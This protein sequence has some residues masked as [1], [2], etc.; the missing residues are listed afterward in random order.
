MVPF[1][2]NRRFDLFLNTTCLDVV[3]EEIVCILVS[4]S[5]SNGNLIEQGELEGGRHHVLWEDPFK[6][7]CYLFAL[8]LWKS[9]KAQMKHLSLTQVGRFPEDLDTAQDLAKTGER[10]FAVLT[11]LDLM[12]KGTNVVDADINRNVDMIPARRREHEY[13]ASSPDYGHLASKMGSEYLAKLLSKAV[14]RAHIPNITSLIN[15]TIDELESEMDHLGRPIALDAG[16]EGEFIFPN[17]FERPIPSILRDYSAPICLDFDLTQ[18]DT[19]FLLSMIRMNLIDDIGSPFYIV[20][21]LLVMVFYAL[22]DGKQP[23]LISMGAI[24]LNAFLDWLLCPWVRLGTRTALALFT[25]LSRKLNQAGPAG[26]FDATALVRPLFHRRKV[27]KY[28]DRKT[29]QMDPNFTKEGKTKP[30]KKVMNLDTG[31]EIL[32]KGEASQRY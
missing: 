26:L 3:V 16:K 29:K 18:S 2:N 20:R 23:F 14:I 28:R 25:L 5:L 32:D 11:K 31:K 10:T 17:I 12:D 6:K 27:K 21:E 24:S 8:V 4:G 13:F 7:P 1:A 22:G 9:W 30:L 19:L 15:K